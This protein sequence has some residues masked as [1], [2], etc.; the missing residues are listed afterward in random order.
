MK[1]Q[2]FNEIKPRKIVKI[3]KYEHNFSWLEF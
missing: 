2:N 1:N 3:V